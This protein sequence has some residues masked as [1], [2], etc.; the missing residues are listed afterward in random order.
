M[1][2]MRG[3]LFISIVIVAPIAPVGRVLVYLS[4]EWEEEKTWRGVGLISTVSRGKE[5]CS[6]TK[7]GYHCH[8]QLQ[9]RGTFDHYLS[10]ANAG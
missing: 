1:A 9:I 5:G 8:V 10:K 3:F 4:D 2:R 6:A 7:D